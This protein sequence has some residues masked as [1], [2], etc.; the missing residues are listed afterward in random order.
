MEAGVQLL[1]CV[2]EV[3]VRR[4]SKSF[5]GR[6]GPTRNFYSPLAPARTHHGQL[7][8]A[9]LRQPARILHTGPIANKFLTPSRL[10]RKLQPSSHFFAA[11][12]DRL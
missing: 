2:G 9:P 11:L 1:F 6:F 12:A 10:P 5:Y 4:V 7:P 3:A 8:D